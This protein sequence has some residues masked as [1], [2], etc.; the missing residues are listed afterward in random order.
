MHSVTFTVLDPRLH[1]GLKDLALAIQATEQDMQLATQLA[2]QAGGKVVAGAESLQASATILASL[3]QSM[4][5]VGHAFDELGGQSM[6]IG[7]L[8]GSIQD[9]AKQTNLLAL[10][11]SIEAARAGDHGRGFAVVADEVR[12]LAASVA[13]CSAQIKQIAHMLERSAQEARRSIDP[14]GKAARDGL[15]QSD[16]ALQA[17]QGLRDAAV[18][19]MQIVERVM[20]RLKTQKA[21]TSQVEQLVAAAER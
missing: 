12:K 21:L 2:Q 3:D 5:H 4:Q 13:E 11:A 15:A 16:L 14:L 6:R 1:Q 18:E 19:R 10:N 17:L 9:I 7:S 8:V 20:S